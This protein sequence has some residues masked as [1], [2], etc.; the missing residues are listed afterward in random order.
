MVHIFTKSSPRVESGS[1]KIIR[2]TNEQEE[3]EPVDVEVY[4]EE[5]QPNKPPK[6]FKNSATIL[7]GLCLINTVVY[8]K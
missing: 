1:A 2:I 5:Y 3:T 6:G 8:I 7:I 4:Y